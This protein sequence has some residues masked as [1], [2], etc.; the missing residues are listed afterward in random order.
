MVTMN[1]LGFYFVYREEWGR[2]WEQ[3]KNK[4]FYL[5]LFYSGNSS[6]KKY[7]K[8]ISCIM[9]CMCAHTHTH[10]S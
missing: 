9:Q 4:L 5:I 3:E 6:S 7:N 1:I 8:T 10:F 2:Q